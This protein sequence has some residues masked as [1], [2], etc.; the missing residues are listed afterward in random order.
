MPLVRL[1]AA[2]RVLVVL[3]QLGELLKLARRLADER[4]LLE[5][6]DVL[7]SVLLAETG[8]VGE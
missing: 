1:L 5:Q 4:A 6:L 8:D 7:E 2:D 3:A